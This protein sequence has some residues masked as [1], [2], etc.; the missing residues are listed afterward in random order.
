L[1]EARARVALRKEVTAED[2]EAAITIMRK[3]LEEVGIDMA[4]HRMDIDV[5]MTGKP[6]S[7]RDKLQVILGTI[8]EM[9]KETGMVEKKV[10]LETL[11]TKHSISTGEA[12]RL[13]N[14]MLKEG[15]LYSPRDGFLKKT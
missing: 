8:L 15:T 10:L 4:S 1:A 5:I 14:Q 13:L 12:E 9:E 2:A 6:K 11:E 3:S 7:L